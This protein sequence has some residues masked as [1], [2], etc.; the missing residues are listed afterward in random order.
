MKV[1]GEFSQVSQRYEAERQSPRE[2]MLFLVRSTTESGTSPDAL[3]PS[4]HKSP[5]MDTAELSRQPVQLGTDLALGTQ[6]LAF[7]KMIRLTQGLNT[8]LSRA[9]IHPHSPSG[10][11]CGT[12]NGSCLLRSVLRVFIEDNDPF[13]PQL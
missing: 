11:L 9:R 12:L 1:G 2:Q 3:Q 7:S 5:Q 8:W 4:M 6:T 13:S 10:T